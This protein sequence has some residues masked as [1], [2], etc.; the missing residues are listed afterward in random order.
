MLAKNWDANV[1]Y[2]VKLLPTIQK[3]DAGEYVKLLQ[4]ELETMGYYAGGT[5]GYFGEYTENALKQFQKNINKVYGNFTV[6][7]ICGPKTWT[8]IFLG[9]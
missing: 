7:G 9:K 5:D 8:R 2:L 4:G 6:D 3:G 1:E